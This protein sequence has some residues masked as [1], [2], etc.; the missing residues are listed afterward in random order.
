MPP[1]IKLTRPELKRY[2]DALS[3]Y[4]QYLPM[5]K[6]KQ[7]Q[8]QIALRKVNLERE[9]AVAK[10]HHVTER[11]ASYRSILNDVAGVNLK[12]LSRPTEI[13]TTV[14]NIAG[15][16]I[17]V[18]KCVVFSP[19]EYTLF[20]T[21]AWVDQRLNDQKKLAMEQAHLDIL[22][23]QHDLLQYEYQKISQRVNLFEKVKIPEARQVVQLIRIWLGD[24]MATAVGRAKL[25]KKTTTENL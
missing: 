19:L 23:K 7:M 1:K 2:R 18:F 10:V 5:L 20:G 16:K 21:P 17:P 9:A 15:L 12:A 6:L 8:L 11:L 25:L 13:Q 22:E 14:T 24:E 4:E 3:R